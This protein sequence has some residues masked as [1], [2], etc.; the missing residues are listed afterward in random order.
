[1]ART[2]KKTPVDTKADSKVLAVQLNARELETLRAVLEEHQARG[3][4]IT[5]SQLIRWALTHVDFSEIPDVP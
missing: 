3:S 1:M 2:R 5:T 4:R